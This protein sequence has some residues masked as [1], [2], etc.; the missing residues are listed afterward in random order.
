MSTSTPLE[1]HEASETD[2]RAAEQEEQKQQERVGG[3]AAA[4][5]DGDAAVIRR[6][7]V[8]GGGAAGESVVGEDWRANPE[9]WCRYIDPEPLRW[10]YG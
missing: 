8:I 10:G 2:T 4:A 6:V 9:F 1:K 7:A 5:V 3:G